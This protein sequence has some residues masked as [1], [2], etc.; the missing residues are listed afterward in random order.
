L[1]KRTILFVDDEQNILEGL[2]TRLHRQ[3]N[4]WE[5]R[6]AL[7]GKAAMEILSAEH[8]DVLVT[9]MRMPEMDGLTLLKLAQRDHPSVVRI[10]LSGHAEMEA[11]LR[12]IHVAHQFLTKPCEAGVI[13]NTVDRACN[14][15]ELINNELVREI[16]GK[17]DNLPSPPIVYSGLMVALNNEFIGT[18]QVADIL[19]R[20]I[21][22]CAKTL[23]VVNSALFHVARKITEIEDAVTFLG[24]NTIRQIVLSVEVFNAHRKS[25]LAGEPLE[26]MQNHACLVGSLA[27]R[28]FPGKREQEDAF[29]SGLLHDIGK[30]VLAAHLPAAFLEIQRTMRISG[31]AMVEAEQQVLGV[32]HAEIG[33]YLLGLWGLPYPIVEAV[34]NHHRPERVES[35]EFGVLAG[36]YV[37]DRLIHEVTPP[38]SGAEA[39]ES[40]LDMAH[41]EKLGVAAHVPE[42]RAMAEEELKSG[43]RGLVSAMN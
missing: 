23:Q 39:T 1:S 2:R 14:L 32:T 30:L 4:K 24:Y 7:S 25:R 36:V 22:M 33:A 11:A 13:E 17:V 38:R 16:V 37:A 31:G 34:A 12:A 5:M 20:D 26:S 41:L 43:A 21:A 9:D 40:G 19:R 29:I 27:S 6:F 3:R 28:M 8:V 15:Q 35:S 18:R 42:W 10:V